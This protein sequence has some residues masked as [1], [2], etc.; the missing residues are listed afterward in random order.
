MSAP[1]LAIAAA[2]SSVM[3]FSSAARWNCTFSG[4]GAPQ[5]VHVFTGPGLRLSQLGQTHSSWTKPLLSL[6]AIFRS[7]SSLISG[8]KYFTSI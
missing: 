2:F 8:K 3:S 7:L 5:L 1:A 6:L 4:W